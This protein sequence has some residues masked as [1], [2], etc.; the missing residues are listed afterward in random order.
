MTSD[1]NDTADPLMA[2]CF[3]EAAHAIV[4][5]ALGFDVSAVYILGDGSGETRTDPHGSILADTAR[6]RAERQVEI[7]LAGSIAERRYF[8]IEGYKPDAEHDPHWGQLDD[9]GRAWREALAGCGGDAHKARVLMD[10][11]RVRAEREV[12]RTWGYVTEL[13]SELRESGNVPGPTLNRILTSV[14][15]RVD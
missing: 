7:A 10:K 15:R 4:A 3:H 14:P 8:E 5:D 6:E 11:S 2:T 9:D 13:A 12:E 1:D